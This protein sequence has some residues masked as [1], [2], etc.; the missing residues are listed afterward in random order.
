MGRAKVA[1]SFDEATLQRLDRLVAEDMFPNRGQ[2]IEVAVAEKLQR[3]DPG[4]LAREIR[5]LRGLRCPVPI[6]WEEER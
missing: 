1:I 6:P 3:L 5:T 2:A 4:R